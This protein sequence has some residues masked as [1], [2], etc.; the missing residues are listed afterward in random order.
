MQSFR[1]SKGLRKCA[2]W[3]QHFRCD[4]FRICPC[5]F[6]NPRVPASRPKKWL[7]TC[8]APSLFEPCSFCTHSPKRHAQSQKLMI[9]SWKAK[10]VEQTAYRLFNLPYALASVRLSLPSSRMAKTSRTWTP[11][12]SSVSSLKSPS[13]FRA[14]AVVVPPIAEAPDDVGMTVPLSL[15]LAAAK[16]GFRP[17]LVPR[18]P[19]PPG[20]PPIIQLYF[21]APPPNARLTASDVAFA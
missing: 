7:S 14:L 11:L 8:T 2:A 19:P 18:P 1:N 20:F 3:T 15:A 16:G 4:P 9:H 21:F 6:P 10:I 12:P 17:K 13:A 5:A